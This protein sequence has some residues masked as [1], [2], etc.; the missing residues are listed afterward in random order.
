MDE[1]LQASPKES[2]FEVRGLN[3]L[4]ESNLKD[5]YEQTKALRVIPV[6]RPS[7]FF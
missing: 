2:L 7:M 5:F 3:F 4:R 1:P 6:A